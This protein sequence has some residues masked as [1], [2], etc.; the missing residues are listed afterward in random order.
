[1]ANQSLEDRRKRLEALAC[2]IHGT[3]ML[4]VGQ[5]SIDGY[6]RHFVVVE[7]P[8]HDCDVQAREYSDGGAVVLEP[9]HAHL[10]DQPPL[11]P[12]LYNVVTI[13]EAPEILFRRDT[14]ERLWA[15]VRRHKVR[16]Q[17]L[18]GQVLSSFLDR[19]DLD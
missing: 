19:Q 2:P 16:W 11:D 8:R 5:P 7:C 10:T 14:T 18:I 4:P 6:G 12:L 13:D 17:D 1:M 15:Y 9:D 3:G